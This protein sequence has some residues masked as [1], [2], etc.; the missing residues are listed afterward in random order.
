MLNDKT[1]KALKK[2]ITDE[3]DPIKTPIAKIEEDMK[4]IKDIKKMVV[5]LREEVEAQNE[6]HTN[7][8]KRL[9]EENEY[10][11]QRMNAM[12]QYSMKPEVIMNGIKEEDDE[13][14]DDL[15]KKVMEISKSLGAP[16]ME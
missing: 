1:L 16:L 5:D 15:K 2:I 7:E 10:L 9:K 4:E 12:E 6:G 3:L 14:D 11:T 13:D 8:I